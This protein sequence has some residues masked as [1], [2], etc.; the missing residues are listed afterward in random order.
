[1]VTN[2]FVQHIMSMKLQVMQS[3]TSVPCCFFQLL[4]TDLYSAVQGFQ[5]IILYGYGS[6]LEHVNPPK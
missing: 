4:G 5:D 2:E 6:N 1:M 3:N